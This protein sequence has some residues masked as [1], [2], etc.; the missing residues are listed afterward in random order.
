MDIY[1]LFTICGGLAFFLF[2]M[3]VMSGS[4]EKVAGSKLSDILRALTS[5]PFKSLALGA[6]ITI[7][8]QSSSALTVMLVG[9]VNSGIMSVQQTIGVIMGSNIGTT[10]TSWILSLSGLRTENFFISLLKPENFSPIVALIGVILIM[11][12]KTA[13]KKDVGTIMAG[14]AVLMY[15]MQIMSDAV[16]PLADMPEFSYFLTAFSNPFLGVLIGTLF[17]GLIQSSAAAVGVLQALSMTGAITYAMAAPIVMGANI[18][19][20]ITA[21]LS[22]F[23][24]GK[25]AKKVPLIH[26]LIKIIGTVIGLIAYIVLVYIL[27]VPAAYKACTPFA[28]AMI[29]TI[30]N[31]VNTIVLLPFSRQLVALANKLIKSDASE[32]DKVAF[33]DER[34]LLSPG[35]AV[36]Q[37][38]KKSTTL[39]QLSA[40][41]FEIATKAFRDF[42][43][44]EIEEIRRIENEVDMMEDG[45]NTF[46]SK[47]SKDLTDDDNKI[48]NEILHTISDFERISDHAVDLTYIAERFHTEGFDFIDKEKQELTVLS[49]AL[50]EILHETTDA[51]RSGDTAAA[52]KVEPH[53]SFVRKMI[54]EIKDRFITR[55]QSH[56]RNAEI[57][58][59][60][61]DFLTIYDRVAAHCSN[62]AM[63]VEENVAEN[64]G[65]H[66]F[67]HELHGDNPLDYKEEKAAFIARHTLPEA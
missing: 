5:N 35:L 39:A 50:F 13:R 32:K 65:M 1:S 46:L 66:T 63:S 62:I 52:K 24:V 29:H 16:S 40:A 60:L 34:L 36:H 19:T 49:G 11:T 47:L 64:L 12:G 48:V 42:N 14:F 28:V 3:H 25:E 43:R 9:L 23:G 61:N 7:A 45:L 67:S 44:E 57:I 58:T 8:I 10:L 22:A 31:V 4:L 27:Q 6:V 21:V 37:S 15:G 20:C 33:L 51:Y 26:V 17:T 54:K 38:W 55:L 41:S 53:V 18:G 30:F 2:G 59:Y 56:E